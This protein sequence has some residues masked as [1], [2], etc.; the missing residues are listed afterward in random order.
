VPVDDPEEQLQHDTEELDERIDRVGEHIE[1]SRGKLKDR[2]EDAHEIG[3]E[4]A[5]ALGDE[6]SD[7]AQDGDPAGFDDPEEVDELDVKEEE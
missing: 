7:D 2:Q 3:D 4:D 5:D 1:E 6:E